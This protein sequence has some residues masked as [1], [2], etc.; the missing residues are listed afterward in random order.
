M[1][2]RCSKQRNIYLI[3]AKL[4]KLRKDLVYLSISPFAF[5]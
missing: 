3:L 2:I 1:N 5:A 4:Y